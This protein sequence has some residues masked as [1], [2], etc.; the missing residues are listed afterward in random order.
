MLESGRYYY[1]NYRRVCVF[2]REREKESREKLTTAI[3]TSAVTDRQTQR[4]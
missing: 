4:Y 3:G 2:G 1:Y